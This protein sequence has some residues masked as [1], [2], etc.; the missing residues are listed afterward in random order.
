MGIMVICRDSSSS[1]IHHWTQ[2]VNTK[3]AAPNTLGQLWNVSHYLLSPMD[4]VQFMTFCFEFPITRVIISFSNLHHPEIIW[5]ITLIL[6]WG[7]EAVTHWVSARCH[8]A[9]RHGGASKAKQ[10]PQRCTWKRA[11]MWQN[12]NQNSCKWYAC[13]W[14]YVQIHAIMCYISIWLLWHTT[15]D[16]R[17]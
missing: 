7:A 16:I 13:S 5:G 3:N 11:M 9:G 17:M 4:D 1:R 12:G 10:G 14:V 6:T 2:L 8:T 15:Y